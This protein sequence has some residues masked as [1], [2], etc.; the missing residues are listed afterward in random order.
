MHTLTRGAVR[1]PWHAIVMIAGAYMAIG[2]PQH[3]V[4][5]GNAKVNPDVSA[6]GSYWTEERFRNAEPM[7][8]P[9][10]PADRSEIRRPMSSPDSQRG[11]ASPGAPPSIE[12]GDGLGLQLYELD[13]REEKG[14]TAPQPKRSDALRPM[15]F[16]D[17]G[18][19]FTNSRVLPPG[20]TRTYP[21][22]AIGKL[23]IFDGLGGATCSGA[24]IERRLVLTAAH[25]VYDEVGDFFFDH[26]TFVPAYDRGRAPLGR[27]NWQ[28]V[29]VTTS[30]L[31]SDS[32]FPNNADFAIIQ[33]A[34]RRVGGRRATIGDVTGWLGWN[35]FATPDNHLTS[36]GYPGNLDRGERLQQTH[37]QVFDLEFPNAFLFGSYHSQGASGGPVA[38]N[39]GQRALGQ[40]ASPT[41]IIG[42]NSFE[43][44]ADWIVGASILNDEFLEI[45]GQACARNRRNCSA[46]SVVAGTLSTQ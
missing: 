3:A 32:S 23:F 30:W 20:A 39:F 40:P 35:A 36:L 46:T 5:E 26:F 15:A 44:L 42:V 12:G 14:L 11:A 9:V 24:V 41:R 37:A 34:D 1:R 8:M 17:S 38:V 43:F 6:T 28:M 31:N 16:A 19:A 18:A 45:L 25:C 22:R 21:Y 7:P 33:V 29:W 13:K 27:W 4:A 10:G 2:L